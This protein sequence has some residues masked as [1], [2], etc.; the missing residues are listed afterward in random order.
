MNS[1]KLQIVTP[2]GVAWN[3][4]AESLLVHT[5]DGDVEILAGHVDYM[6]SVATGRARIITGGVS[7]FA[8]CSGGFLHVS[9]DGVKLVAVTFELAE[10]ID[11]ARAMK[12]K[13]LAEARLAAARDE[14]EERLAR[15]KLRRALTRISVSGMK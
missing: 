1:F 3:G 4:D 14:K 13:D 15:A 5:D 8:S 7:K 2:D 9:R 12:A 11:A 6:A 10:N